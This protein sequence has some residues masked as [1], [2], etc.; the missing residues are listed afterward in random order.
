M[1]LVIEQLTSQ[2]PLMVVLTGIS[3]VTGAVVMDRTLFWLWTAAKRKP[4][5]PEL[6]AGSARNTAPFLK[7]YLEKRSRHYTEQVLLSAL[8]RPDD[9]QH[10]YQTITEQIDQMNAKLGMLDL[11]A[12]IAPL[13]GILGTVIGMA[14]SFGGIS[15]MVSAS[16]AAISSGISVALKTTAYGLIISIAASVAAAVFRKFTNQATIKMGRIIC[17]FAHHKTA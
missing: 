1:N 3:V 16:P 17:E 11:A 7:Q 9:S 8:Q 4:I 5:P 13:V 12:K 10:Q 15:K 6:L 2:N 14:L